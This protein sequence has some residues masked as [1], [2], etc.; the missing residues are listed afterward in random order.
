M[1]SHSS[2]GLGSWVGSLTGPTGTSGI[3]LAVTVTGAR[4]TLLALGFWNARTLHLDLSRQYTG[5][6]REGR[7]LTLTG[8]PHTLQ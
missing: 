5:R 3:W 1:A 8:L 2:A 6:P 4:S 7:L